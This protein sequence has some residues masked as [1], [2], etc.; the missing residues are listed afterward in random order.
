MEYEICNVTL[1]LH[2]TITTLKKARKT[3]PT[4]TG[5]H[6]KDTTLDS[7]MQLIVNTKL[8]SRHSSG[9]YRT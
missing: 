3:M 2:I 9:S 4:L 1:M 8:S 6:Y 5:H 7:T